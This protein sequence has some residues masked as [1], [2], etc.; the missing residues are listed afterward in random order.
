MFGSHPNFGFGFGRIFVAFIPQ[1]YDKKFEIHGSAPE[2]APIEG[3]PL[4]IKIVYWVI[5]GAQRV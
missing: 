1:P 5:A 2:F 3:P 4:T